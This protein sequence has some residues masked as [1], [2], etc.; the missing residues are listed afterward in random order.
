MDKRVGYRKMY[1]VDMLR[2]IGKN[3]WKGYV[4]CTCGILI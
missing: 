1:G 2:D 4:V 3:F